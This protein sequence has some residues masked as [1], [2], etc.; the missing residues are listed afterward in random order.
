MRPAAPGAIR[1][2]EELVGDR[3]FVDLAR[4]ISPAELQR[5]SNEYKRVTGFG[6]EDVS[7]ETGRA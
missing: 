7:A 5:L 2:V 6:L 1:R 3:P 4:H